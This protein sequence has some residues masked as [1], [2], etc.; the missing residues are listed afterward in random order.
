MEASGT[1]AAASKGWADSHP[2]EGEKKTLTAH[3]KQHQHGR[4]T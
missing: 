2:F 3:H 1:E 4:A